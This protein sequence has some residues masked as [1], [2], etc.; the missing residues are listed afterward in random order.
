MEIVR[1]SDEDGERENETS[2]FNMVVPKGFTRNPLLGASICAVPLSLP[3]PEKSY[4]KN[5]LSRE[6]NVFSRTSAY[7]CGEKKN[8]DERGKLANKFT[9]C[10]ITVA[11]AFIPSLTTEES[12]FRVHINNI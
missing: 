11:P 5:R 4:F 1:G 12:W 7:F 3:I 10:S 2:I 8:G 9:P 6:I